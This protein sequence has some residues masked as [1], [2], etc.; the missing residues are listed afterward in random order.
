MIAGAVKG[1]LIFRRCDGKADVGIGFMEIDADA[2]ETADKQDLIM[3]C[4]AN[5]G[6]GGTMRVKLHSVRHDPQDLSDSDVGNLVTSL[7]Y[8]RATEGSSGGSFFVRHSRIP[9]PEGR[10]IVLVALVIEADG[11]EIDP[12]VM[13]EIRG[14]DGIVSVQPSGPHG[15]DLTGMALSQIH[16][17]SIW[18]W[19][20]ERWGPVSTMRLDVLDMC[21]ELDDAMLSDEPTDPARLE[22]LNRS[23]AGWILKSSHRDPKYEDFKRRMIEEGHRS[24][25]AGILTESQAKRRDEAGARIIREIM[26]NEGD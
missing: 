23:H 17:S 15:L 7:Q 16:R 19:D 11:D 5:R 8:P 10:R 25:W 1:Q 12:M 21:Q 14:R 13:H 6:V 20:E 3:D 26:Q 4:L 22:E 9:A 2:A 18:G 24:E